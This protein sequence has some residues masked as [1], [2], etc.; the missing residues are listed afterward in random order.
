MTIFEGCWERVVKGLEPVLRGFIS[1]LEALESRC[2][3]FSSD[4][5]FSL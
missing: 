5:I 2:C 4:Y 1:V 3:T